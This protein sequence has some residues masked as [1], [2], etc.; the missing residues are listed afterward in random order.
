MCVPPTEK[1]R[2]GLLDTTFDPLCNFP[3]RIGRC[4]R[5]PDSSGVELP[6]SAARVFRK[7]QSG[8][9]LYSS[10]GREISGVKPAGHDASRLR[11]LR[12][13][14]DAAGSVYGSEADFNGEPISP[15]FQEHMRHPLR[16]SSPPLHMIPVLG[17]APQRLDLGTEVPSTAPPSPWKG[18]LELFPKRAPTTSSSGKP[19]SLDAEHDHPGVWLTMPNSRKQPAVPPSEAGGLRPPPKAWSWETFLAD[20]RRPAVETAES[21]LARTTSAEDCLESSDPSGVFIFGALGAV[22]L[23]LLLA[24]AVVSCVACVQ[25]RRNR[26][27][28]RSLKACAATVME[29]D[30]QILHTPQPS[31][32]CPDLHL[33]LHQALASELAVASPASACSTC[34]RWPEDFG[35]AAAAGA[36][37][38]VQENTVGAPEDDARAPATAPPSRV[39][40]SHVR[41]LSRHSELACEGLKVAKA[42]M[43]SSTRDRP[44]MTEPLPSRQLQAQVLKVLE[45]LEDQR[46]SFPYRHRRGG[47]DGYYR[48]SGSAAY[49]HGDC[50]APH[51]HQCR[52]QRHR[53]RHSTGDAEDRNRLNLME[54]DVGAWRREYRVRSVSRP[55]TCLVGYKLRRRRR[56]FLSD[57]SPSSSS[58]LD[59]LALPTPTLDVTPPGLRETSHDFSVAL[60]SPDSTSSSVETIFIPSPGVVANRHHKRA[61]SRSRMERPHGA[62]LPAP[63]QQA[64]SPAGA[65]PAQVA[66]A[67]SLRQDPMSK[68]LLTPCPHPERLTSAPPA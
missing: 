39:L 15:G 20:L 50:A 14:R 55:R 25:R 60:R 4:G 5:S 52:V 47:S 22:L 57:E 43:F 17:T 42:T 6:R 44:P 31:A 11:G 38:S 66:S 67:Q 62:P 58:D 49:E 1:I 54:P 32:V 68:K 30:A 53:R 41:R 2:D 56:Q 64:H 45:M 29:T 63:D 19:P 48:R 46:R 21:L 13:E 51:C 28:R 61:N 8:G 18:W 40:S 33:P 7:F 3:P 12:V 24:L 26:S 65:A 34:G 59:D 16:A 9:M 37:E 27:L 10:S 35:Q 23:L 36:A